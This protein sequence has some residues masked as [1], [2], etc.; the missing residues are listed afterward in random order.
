MDCHPCEMASYAGAAPR[1]VN[2]H[3]PGDHLQA[4]KNDSDPGVAN[5]QQW[6][7][8]Q[9]TDDGMQYSCQAASARRSPRAVTL[10]GE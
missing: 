5:R 4:G 10:S 9:V 6:I 1:W 7:V 3:G 2:T 8:Q